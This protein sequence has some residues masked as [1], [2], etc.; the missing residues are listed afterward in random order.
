MNAREWMTDATALFLQTVE[1]LSDADL[2]APTALPGWSRQHVVA[3]VHFNAEALLRLT[4]WASTGVES[5]MYASPEQRNAEIARGAALPAGEL[6][7]LVAGSAERLGATLAHFSPDAWH[8]T[9]VTAQ[10][11]T[12]PATEI[13]W[14]RAR[15]VAVHT[16]DLDAGVGFAD[17]PAN[18]VTAL[19]TE[20]ATKRAASGEGPALAAWLTGRATEAPQL[21]RWL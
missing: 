18:F 13:P 16:V 9:V 7:D 14:M 12:V 8:A 15:E 4:A 1:R 17:L 11:R 19:V 5:R 10:G 2:D 6:R 20:V 3:H 21:G